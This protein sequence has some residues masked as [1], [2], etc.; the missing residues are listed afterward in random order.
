MEAAQLAK[1]LPNHDIF[2]DGGGLPPMVS[3]S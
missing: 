2:D 1:R 3:D